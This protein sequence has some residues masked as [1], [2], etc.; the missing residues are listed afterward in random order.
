MGHFYPQGLN[1]AVRG[2]AGALRPT[3]TGTARCGAARRSPLATPAVLNEF[4]SDY[5]HGYFRG[6]FKAKIS[7][8]TQIR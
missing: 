7:V 5:T 2:A 8:L 4:C 3:E 1:G 6:R